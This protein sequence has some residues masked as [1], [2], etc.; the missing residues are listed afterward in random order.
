MTA[1]RYTKVLTSVLSL[2]GGAN[3]LGRPHRSMREKRL[4]FGLKSSMCVDVRVV[5]T[6]RHA[7]LRPDRRLIRGSCQ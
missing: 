2:C 1:S 7:T 6:D 5:K 3:W 4:A